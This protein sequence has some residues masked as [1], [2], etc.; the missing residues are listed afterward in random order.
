MLQGR[1]INHQALAAHGG[2]ERITAVTSFRPRDPMIMDNSV[3]TTIR[4]ISDH[5]QLY[6]QWSKYRIEVLQKRLQSLMTVVEEQHR[7]NLPTDKELLKDF[8]EQQE[9][10]LSAT[11]KEIV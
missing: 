5:S 8:F 10:W 1:C 6:Y 9:A 4:P 3:L 2:G 7:A 11:R